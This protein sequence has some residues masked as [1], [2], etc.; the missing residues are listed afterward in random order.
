MDGRKWK[1]GEMDK[2][3]DFFK[4]TLKC[5]QSQET[6]RRRRSAGTGPRKKVKTN[7]LGKATLISFSIATPRRPAGAQIPEANSRKTQGRDEGKRGHRLGL[8]KNL[9]KSGESMQLKPE[10]CNKGREGKKRRRTVEG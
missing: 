4:K 9:P 1:C 10:F 6:W 3:E 5:R 8:A 2:E 7:A